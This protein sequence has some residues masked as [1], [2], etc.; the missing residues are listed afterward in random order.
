MN[1]PIK[2]ASF[3]HSFT[4]IRHADNTFNRVL[5]GEAPEE[6][7]ERSSS[8]TLSRVRFTKVVTVNLSSLFSRLGFC[9]V[10]ETG[11]LSWLYLEGSS[12]PIELLL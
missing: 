6:I 7:R 1:V 4:L 10:S 2:D 12:H 3:G 5:L 9:L 8:Q 11:E